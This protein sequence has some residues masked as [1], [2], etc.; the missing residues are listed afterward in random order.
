MNRSFS[1]RGGLDF[2][3]VWEAGKSWSHP[4]IILRACPNGMETSRFGF[5]VGKKIGKAV[6]RNRAKRLI[7]EVVRHRLENIAQGWDLIFI[8]RAGAEQAE[9]K[10]IE[11]A[12]EQVLQKA[13]LGRDGALAIKDTGVN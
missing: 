5:V 1:L 11:Q 13:R 2:Q 12:V 8:A 4:L 7:R 10:D 9:L 3:R 6:A